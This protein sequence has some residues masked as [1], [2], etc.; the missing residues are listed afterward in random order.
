[1]L[2]VLHFSN[3]FHLI[4]ICRLAER[5]GEINK[6]QNVN[7]R[8][9]KKS[10]SNKIEWVN[11]KKQAILVFF[12]HSWKRYS[13]EANPEPACRRLFWLSFTNKHISFPYF[14][15]F[16]LPVSPDRG[17]KQQVYHTRPS[18]GTPTL[19]TGGR[20]HWWNQI[21]QFYILPSRW[22]MF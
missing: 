3:L 8:N 2:N 22:I 6:F 5:T 16:P 11:E 14:S 9:K 13:L 18:T 1:M 20:D 12:F 10:K 15:P 21:T 7:W 17:Q 4:D 19:Y